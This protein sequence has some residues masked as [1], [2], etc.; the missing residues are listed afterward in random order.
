MTTV[1]ILNGCFYRVGK[2]G[3]EYVMRNLWD[4]ESGMPS[5]VFTFGTHGNGGTPR[6]LYGQIPVVEQ[7]YFGAWDVLKQTKNSI[8]WKHSGS[9]HCVKFNTT[10][11]H[12]ELM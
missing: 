5:L 8:A 2:E 7:F 4:T 3:N 12:V 1:K 11:C 10:T 9:K 6:A